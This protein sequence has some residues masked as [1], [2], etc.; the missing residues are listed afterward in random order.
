MGLA[1][2]ALVASD[3]MAFCIPACGGAC[4][5]EGAILSETLLPYA[6]ISRFEVLCMKCGFRLKN[7]RENETQGKIRG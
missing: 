6:R 4:R 1:T 3:A 2:G 5:N 7:R